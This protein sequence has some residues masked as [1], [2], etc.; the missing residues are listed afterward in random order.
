MF[1]ARRR[2]APRVVV[3]PIGFV[4][5]HMEV[6]YDLDTEAQAIAAERGIRM[7]RAG[8]VGVHP[9]FIAMIRELIAER[10]GLCVPRAIGKYPRPTMSAGPIAAPAPARRAAPAAHVSERSAPRQLVGRPRASKARAGAP[11]SSL[12]PCAGLL[13]APIDRPLRQAAASGISD[14]SPFAIIRVISP[15]S[16]GRTANASRSSSGVP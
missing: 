1:C 12:L 15:L 8:T 2:L 14:V 9:K 11:R 3:A 7:V 10:M 13:L 16:A 4:S 6:L 5:D